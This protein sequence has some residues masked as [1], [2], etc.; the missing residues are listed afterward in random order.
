[1]AKRASKANEASVSQPQRYGSLE[2]NNSVAHEE[3]PEPPPYSSPV[4]AQPSLGSNQQ[5]PFRYLSN[6]PSLPNLDYSKYQIPECTVSKDGTII[7]Y[8][9]PLCSDGKAL[10]QFIKEQ[11]ALPPLPYIRILGGSPRDL[12][13]DF[14]VRINMLRYFLPTRPSTR[15]NYLKLVEDGQLAF[16]GKNT[17]TTTPNAKNGIEDWA[18]RFCSEN[19][20][21][22]TFTL[23]RHITNWDTSYIEG[24]IR[25]LI[26]ATGYTNH[27]T[28]TFPV[29]YSKITVQPRGEGFI[30][31]LF[32][33]I[34]EKRRYEVA[35]AVWPYATLPPGLESE[36]A[37]RSC[38]V[39]TEEAWWR[40]WKDVLKLAIVTRR[41]GWVT[42]DDILEFRMS[43]IEPQIP[44]NPWG[45]Q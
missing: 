10:A 2:D 23:E 20:S 17:Q 9:R 35:R 13:P 32:S 21:L 18:R 7:T 6:N 8:H 34:L 30:A 26:A 1:M 37:G 5:R 43:P 45:Y 11:A 19:S 31:T 29:R 12:Q 41:H 42:L 38:A 22:K 14:D 4:T 44:K 27:V 24:Q 25:S 33:P 36:D 16:R 39:Q 28:V 15:L 3:H 40:D